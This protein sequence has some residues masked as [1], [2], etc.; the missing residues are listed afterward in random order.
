MRGLIFLFAVFFLFLSLSFVSAE[1]G[2]IQAY[3]ISD[4][5]EGYI[6]STKYPEIPG[7]NIS[8]KIM[9]ETASQ[10]A[11]ERLSIKVCNESLGC[12]IELKQHPSNNASQVYYIKAEKLAK[13]LW[14]KRNITLEAQVDA[15]TGE[16][17]STSRPW[18][19]RFARIQE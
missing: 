7:K 9:P 6:N 15:E 18:W 11:L 10:I 8:A 5:D 3:V 2:R 13:F 12:T 16:I 4:T 1:I 17:I 19:A 14:I